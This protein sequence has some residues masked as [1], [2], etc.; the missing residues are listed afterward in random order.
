MIRLPFPNESYCMESG[1]TAA[2]GLNATNSWSY[3][4][5]AYGAAA[6]G[7]APDAKAKAANADTS[8]R[9]SN[10]TS[11]TLSDEAKAYLEGERQCRAFAGDRC[12]ECARVF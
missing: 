3:A 4:S 1:V 8:A 11:V 7:A 2:V 10:A 12:G 9:N 5:G 6:G